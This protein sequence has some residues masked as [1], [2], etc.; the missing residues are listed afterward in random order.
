MSELECVTL[1]DDDPDGV[2]VCV[3]ESDAVELAVDDGLGV[4]GG[5]I[6]SVDVALGDGDADGVAD[7]VSE[8]VSVGDSLVVAEGL[9][10]AV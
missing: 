5:V 9:S 10:V 6:V 3:V 7:P 1:S 2:A 4:G 8:L